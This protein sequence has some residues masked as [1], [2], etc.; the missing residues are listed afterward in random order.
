MPNVGR[1]FET[2]ATETDQLGSPFMKARVP[3]MGSTTH[4]SRLSMRAKSSAVSS[5]SQAQWGSSRDSSVLRN[6]STERSASVTGEPPF[7]DQM[8]AVVPSPER[9]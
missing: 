7:F 3:S 6:S 1:P 4:T 9:K 5:D 8:R 2:R